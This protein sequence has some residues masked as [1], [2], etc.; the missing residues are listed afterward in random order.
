VLFLCHF[1]QIVLH[2]VLKWDT[3]RSGQCKEKRLQTALL[4]RGGDWLWRRQLVVFLYQSCC[5]KKKM[6]HEYF[7]NCNF[8]VTAGK[9]YMAPVMFIL[10]PILALYFCPYSSKGPCEAPKTRAA[11][12]RGNWQYCQ[13]VLPFWTQPRYNI[14]YYNTALSVSA[15]TRSRFVC[16][17]KC[18]VKTTQG[19]Q[20]VKSCMLL[21]F[22]HV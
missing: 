17:C 9:S 2:K 7:K 10:W 3:T 12:C 11:D 13:V 8:F 1:V 20:N 4:A 16:V 15:I 21:F 5:M 19:F 14:K 22:A 18:V 6:R